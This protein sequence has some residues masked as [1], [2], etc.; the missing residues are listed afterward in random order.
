MK[1]IKIIIGK[2][3]KYLKEIEENINKKCDKLNKSLKENYEKTNKLCEE[4]NKTV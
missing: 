2:M 3:N 4:M 1:M